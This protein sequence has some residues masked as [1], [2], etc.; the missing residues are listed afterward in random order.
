LTMEWGLGPTDISPVDFEKQVETW[1]ANSSEKGIEELDIR[2]RERL[3]ELGGEYE[4]EIDIVVKLELFEGAS[5]VVLVECKC[6]NP[7]NTIKRDLITVLHGKLN[8][9][10]AHKG[11]IFSTSNFQKGALQYAEKHGIATVLVQ[12]GRAS[13]QTKDKDK[14]LARLRKPPPWRPNYKYVGWMV[15]LTE[16]GNERRHLV[17]D[18]YHEAIK[19]WLAVDKPPA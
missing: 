7:S 1:L 12:D 19:E 16:E 8:D 5:I 9:V 17:A 15:G 18:D 10:G 11:M 2:H 3:E 6:Y 13:Y 14:Q 4:Y